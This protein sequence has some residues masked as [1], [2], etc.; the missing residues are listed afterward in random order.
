MAALLA[1]SGCVTFPRAPDEG[2]PPWIEVNT[3]HFALAT[4]MDRESA[5]E[6]AR[7]LESWWA[8]MGIALP[9][10]GGQAA[11]ADGQSDP[12]LAIALRNGRERDAVHYRIGGIFD[13]LPLLPPVVSI[14]ELEDQHDRETLKH[15]LAHAMLYKRL[16]RVPHWLTEGMA[17]YLQTAEVDRK[18]RVVQWG[19]W[20]AGAMR[21]LL[22][23]GDT[24]TTHRLL[25]TTR[26]TVG[27][28]IGAME[29]Y[30]GLLVH[31]LINRRPQELDCYVLRL[32]K[33]IDP[34]AALAC[35]SGRDKWDAELRDYAY[36][37]S[38][39]R[40]TVAF[41]PPDSNARTAP[42]P[43]ARVHAT[44]ALLDH[45]AMF[46]VLPQFRDE[47]VARARTSL[48]RALELDPHDD[49]ALL[50]T[51]SQTK[52]DERR[53]AE[54]TKSLVADHPGDWRTWV[55]RAETPGLPAAEESQAIEQAWRLAPQQ[56]E[57][58]RLAGFQALR[59]KRWAD[60]RALGVKAWLGGADDREN[61][62]SL[63]LASA[64][65]GAC[66]EAQK[67][68]RS[69]SDSEAFNKEL[70]KAQKQLGLPPAP[71]PAAP[72]SASS[73]SARP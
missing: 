11:A 26:W 68:S 15:E 28:D 41:D 4:D 29:L 69:P 56:T 48:A 40:K 16:P 63:F 25:D 53:H 27:N 73:P 38:F 57:V 9:A 7:T 43:N 13:A 46:T 61:R 42:L 54:I 44:L 59:Q 65:L 39:A 12:V 49:L 35:F 60:A 8:A 5:E 64:L 24:V 58:I 19:Y 55:A 17:V 71:C 50:L 37:W 67:W 18:N 36:S 21:D 14:G 22:E 33:E 10:V 45:I 23:W 62:L 52:V 3:P 47:R 31:M 6:L 70:A 66:W 51:L 72:S 1:G 2:G 34:D 20:N 32:A 30:A